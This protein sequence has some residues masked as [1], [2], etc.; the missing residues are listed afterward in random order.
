MNEWELLGGG[1]QWIGCCRAILDLVVF[2]AA[3]CVIDW[4]ISE[5]RK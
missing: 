5:R 4:R 1:V 3:L 2:V